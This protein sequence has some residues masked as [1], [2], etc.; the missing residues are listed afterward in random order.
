MPIGIATY[1]RERIY[2]EVWAEP[3]SKIAKRYGI[4]GA[5][6]AE[7]CRALDV[8][9]PGRGYWARVAAGQAPPK[10]ELKPP[11]AGASNTVALRCRERIT[12]AP[13]IAAHIEREKTSDAIIV[14]EVLDSPHTLVASAAKILRRAKPKETGLAESGDIRCLDINVAPGSLD[15]ALRVMSTLIVAL[16]HRGLTVEVTPVVRDGDTGMSNATRVLVDGEW[17]RFGLS[18]ECNSEQVPLPKNDKLLRY[19]LSDRE[20]T[21]TV[22]TPNGRLVLTIKTA[23]VGT[24]VSWTDGKRQRVETSL[25]AF[26]AQLYVIAAAIQHERAET[27][28]NR[29]EWAEA[30]L[31]R[32]EEQRRSAEDERRAKALAADL[33]EWRLAR[34][35]REYVKAMHHVVLDANRK[36]IA[37]GA[38]ET[39]LK[40]ADAYADRIDPV[41]RLQAKIRGEL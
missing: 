2:A 8:P 12:P 26:V 27:E 9:V 4:S 33:A 40:W 7:R 21:R 1:D 25:N 31:R 34:E 3:V 41:A 39:S 37:G 28:R 22:Y 14:P 11:R 36:P 23:P 5:A 18:E 19:R 32:E 30:Q 10:P 17:I 24:R 13:E 16:E 15:R 35:I 29:R 38:L 20:L 6:F